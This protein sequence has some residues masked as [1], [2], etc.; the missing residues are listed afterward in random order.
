MALS[1]GDRLGPY[2]VAAPIGRGGMG[3]V[4]RATDTKL[5]RE[6][7]IKVLPAA[8][9]SDPDRL[10]RFQREAEL[11]ASFNHP[12]I[13]AVYGLEES[14]SIRALVMELVE[15]P[16]LAD[17]IAQGAVPVDEALPIAKQIAEALEAAHEQGVIH[18][19][20]KPANITVRPDGAV[21]VLD[22]GL[23]KALDQ[24][25]TSSNVSQLAT[26]TTP[27][28]TQQGVI[29]G[30]A[31][32]MSPEQARGKAVDRRADIWAFGCVLYEMLT[33]RRAFPGDDLSDTLATVLKSEPAWQALPADTPAPIRRLLRR[34]LEKDPKLRLREAGSAIV[35]IHD[36]QTTPAADTPAAVPVA[37]RPA[38][39]RRAL[40]WVA[41]IV[42]G[43]LL[44]GVASWALTQPITRPVT[45]FVVTT[46]DTP[47]FSGIPGRQELAISPDGTRV[48][49]RAS[50]DDRTH[51]YVRRFDQLEGTSLFSTSQ[52]L[53]NPVVSPD[54][55]WVVFRVNDGTWKKVSMLG[56]PAVT[57]FPAEGTP[58]GASWGPDDTITFSQGSGMFRVPAAGGKP[59][60]LATLDT[61]QGEAGH[62]WPEV[63]PGGN[64]VLFTVAKGLGVE[65]ME[66]AVLDLAT[67]ERRTLLPGGSRARY[68]PSGHLIYG[69][70]GTLMAVPFDLDRLQI[71][72]NAVPVAEGVLTDGPSAAVEFAMSADGSLVY[73]SGTNP[74]IRRSLVWVDREGREEVLDAPPRA[75]TSPRISPDGTRVA[76][77]PRDE[78]ND[79]WIWDFVRETLTRL[80]F[81]PGQ[82]RFPLWSPD[83]RR[84]A[85]SSQRDKSRGN[86]FWQAA[87]GTGTVERLAESDRQVFPTS[88]SPDGTR[89]LVYGDAPGNPDDDDVAVVQP[90]G[91]GRLMPLLHTMFREQNAEL[92]PDGRWLAYNSNESGRDEVY[93]RPFPDVEKGRWQVSTG[94]GVQPLW[95]RNGRELFFRS[96]AAL[97]VV[98]VQTDRGF[99]AGNAKV[100]FEG[101]YATPLGGRSYDVSLDGR[102]FLMIKEGA[103][104]GDTARRPQIILVQNW[105]EE[106]KRLLPTR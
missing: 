41:G 50:A 85:F 26:I 47:L 102:R 29:L 75:Y 49:Y 96:G 32:Y 105:S 73:V 15:G 92:S 68:A 44:A 84:I 79:V 63:L 8:L 71:T 5:K 51:L 81:D 3:E 45:R 20:L 19:D 100:V 6:V 34:C 38:P 10:A 95:A 16:T 14:N 55:A 94:G 30:T 65:N 36:A 91:E 18:R 93:V 76:L 31:A 25:G 82:D 97:M 103:A 89:L 42:L 13:A 2:E 57:V 60:L 28:M 12:N 61:K 17:R 72:G 98:P 83:G 11:L 80:T 54:G 48:V 33:G 59:T 24:P 27:A 88:F 66:I 35:E 70:N 64:G 106:L 52:D 86:P 104:A 39:W 43:S 101:V 23:A 40:P 9:A 87:D 1:A 58:R 62:W 4:Y 69:V 67:G 99:A 46:P 7:A 90:Q 37:P 53:A 56:G 77:N 74:G 78:E 21:K 22:F